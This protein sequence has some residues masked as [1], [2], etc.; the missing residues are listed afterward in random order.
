MNHAKSLFN[1]TNDLIKSI[2][3]GIKAGSET[4]WNINHH[5]AENDAQHNIL[6]V[7]LLT[8]TICDIRQTFNLLEVDEY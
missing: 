7:K 3:G 1:L 4:H 2:Q 8:F 5:M 6:K